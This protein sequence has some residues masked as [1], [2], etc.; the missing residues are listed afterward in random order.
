MNEVPLCLQQCYE[1]EVFIPVAIAEDGTSLPDIPRS[2]GPPAIADIRV[3]QRSLRRR[4][5]IDVTVP[6]MFQVLLP[7]V[8]LEKSALSQ[9]RLLVSARL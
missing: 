8:E 7:E 9:P 6:S 3:L 2:A 5:R 1:Y 4:C